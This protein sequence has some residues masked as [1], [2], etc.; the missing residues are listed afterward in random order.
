MA[1]GGSRGGPSRWWAAGFVAG[2][3]AWLACSAAWAAGFA[4]FTGNDSASV[5]FGGNVSTL[6]NGQTS[7]LANDFDLEGDPLT[8]V[9]ETPPQH[10]TLTLNPDGTFLYTHNG[11]RASEDRFRYQAFDRTRYSRVT[12]VII[13]IA[14]PAIPPQIVGQRPLTMPEEG[15]LEIR[16]TDL[17]VND[18][19]SRFPQDF[20]LA[21]DP[22]EGY[23]VQGTTITGAPDF[24][25]TLT[26]PVRVSDGQAESPTFN[27]AVP[28][29]PVN[30]APTVGSPL[31]DQEASEGVPFEVD[32]SQ[33]FSDPDGDPL[34]FSATGLPPSG[35]LV[36]DPATGVIS[37]TPQAADALPQPHAV[38]V[39]A[40]DPGGASASAPLALLIL[41]A[42]VDLALTA[43]ATPNPATFGV[44]PSWTLGIANAGSRA[45]DPGR[46]TARLLS[47][48]GPLRVTVPASCAA[49][50]NATADVTLDCAFD[51]VAPGATTEVVFQT[52][53]EAPGDVALVA[54]LDVDD[55]DDGNNGAAA[56]L[57][58]AGSFGK[59]PAQLLEGAAAALAAGDL[60][61]DGG[62]DV[63]SAGEPTRVFYNAGNRA[64]EAGPALGPE[65]AADGV[66]L[67]DWNADGLP[68]IAAGGRGSRRVRLFLNDGARGFAAGGELPVSG[69]R[70]MA[71]A[72]VD[73]DGA[74]ELVLAGSGG[75]TV[76]ETDGTRRTVHAGAARALAT[77]DVNGDGVT[78]LVVTDAVYRV[79]HVL[80]STSGGDF[81][82]V[83]LNNAGSVASATVADFDGDG[84]P[85]LLLAVDGADLQPPTNVVARNLGNGQFERGAEIGRSATAQLLVGDVNGDGFRDLVSV[86]H[87]GSHQTYFG[88]ARGGLDLQAEFVLSPNARHGTLVYADGDGHLDLLL[89]GPQ[90]P[91]VEFYRNDGLGRFGPGDVTPPVITLVGEPTMNVEVG[92]PF[93]D[94]GAT[95]TDDVEGD[96]T[97]RI[98]VDNP[99]DTAVV[100]SYTVTYEVVDR[101]GN[102]AEPA[103]RTVNVQ[104]QAEASG[105]GGGSAGPLAALALALLLAATRRRVERRGHARKAR[106]RATAR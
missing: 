37:G 62:L 94:P 43:T 84:A 96:L 15:T 18:P 95:A 9:L 70:A 81:T 54:R 92:K 98:I 65:S 52:T 58:L 93:V 49:T 97:G 32:V 61:G 76:V 4:P 53:Q 48:A 87:S 100:G 34:T 26:V 77:G 56:G 59:S 35:S 44:A 86:N 71:A 12:E 36:L 28:V 101:S 67:I 57:N 42:R 21:V 1:R 102:A 23:T 13:A 68:D 14:E 60:D 45:S 17:S 104:P 31:P 82:L 91:S 40:T 99:V 64:F 7:V 8:A 39:T 83:T 69:V 41:P 30:D 50:G 73:G 79:V 3:G 33:A 80:E 24:H 63:V 88:N 78:D 22:G 16:V 90:A 66:A 19:D 72:D 10:G 11:T 106:P 85:D 25:G 5:P 20:T 29:T 89:G 55:G 75:T 38:T 74:A 2:A 105:G 103:H 47:S 27:L 51:P 6:S 46:V